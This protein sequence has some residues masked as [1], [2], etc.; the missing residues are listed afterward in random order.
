MRTARWKN[1]AILVAIL[2]TGGSAS[3]IARRTAE[4]APPPS[5]KFV[6]TSLPLPPTS[7]SDSAGACTVAINPHG[8]GCMSANLSALAGGSFLPDGKHVVAG[9]HFVGGT[10][11]SDTHAGDQLV[12]V[13]TDGTRFANGDAWKCVTCGMPGTPVG[14]TGMD[15]PQTFRDG[16]RLLAGTAIY[17]CSPYLLTDDHCTGTTIKRY[18]IRWQVAPDGSGDGGRI[19]EL[20]LHPDNDHLGFNSVAIN[21][22]RLDQFG[23]I[24]KL[25]FDPGAGR[26]ELD[27]VNRLFRGGIENRTLQPDPAHS[28][29]LRINRQ[30]IEI[31]E[32]RGFTGDGREIVYIGYPWE[33]SNI[34][35]FAVD[36]PTG[37]VRR[38]TS[39]P[40]YVDPVD[41]SP[42]GRWMAIED[43]RGTDRQMYLAAMRGIPPIIDLLT[44]SAVSSTRNNMERRFFNVVLLEAQGDRGDYFGQILTAGI[45]TPGS[46]GDPNWNAN[47]DPRWSPDGRALVYKQSLV[48]SPS[49]GGANPL[50]CPI[51]TEPG[52]RRSRLMIARFPDRK[53]T[54]PL[55]PFV[56]PDAI[57]WGQAYAPGS[58]VPKRALLAAGA[59][60]LDGKDS[61]SAA[62][63]VVRRA[64]GKAIQS[65]SVHYANFSD[66]GRTILNGDEA[67]SEQRPDP[68]TTDILWKSALAQSGAVTGSKLTNPDGFEL[69]IDV[70]VN[71]LQATGTMTTTIDGKI[72]RQPANG[73]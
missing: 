9:V 21:D 14:A 45:T 41:F 1:L 32:F 58:P 72:Y 29:K 33:G 4:P 13:K 52:G 11:A 37:R 68:H 27:K 22:G 66:D 7:P 46:P 15:Y 2:A 31:G 53:P 40:E 23:Y 24:G 16:K 19:R 43:T 54:T 51:S 3:S 35:I 64:D 63:T 71:K 8:T 28:G 70:M 39:H 59:Y 34:D 18:P 47:A 73:M 44:S 56:V 65:M 12:L 69:N 5:E 6:I 50:P 20:R 62:V 38:L 17:D 55:T 61:G 67:V 60:V 36:I 48:T 10:N 49:C 30:A 26:Y 25:R 57:S 42:D